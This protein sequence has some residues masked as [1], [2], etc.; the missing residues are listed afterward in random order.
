[1]KSIVKLNE[2]FSV[3]IQILERAAKVIQQT[4][5]VTGFTAMSKG[6][7]DQDVFTLADMHI[8]NTVKYNL[9]ELY[10]RATIIGEEDEIGEFNTGQPYIMPDEIDK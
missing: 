8:Q 4:R 2:F 3:G 1:M 9:R 7:M 6:R 5:K 10:P